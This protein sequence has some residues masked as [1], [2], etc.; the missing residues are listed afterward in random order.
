MRTKL[1]SFGAF[2]I[3]AGIHL[4]AI[5]GGAILNSLVIITKPLLL[6]LLGIIYYHQAGRVNKAHRNF[7]LAAL[8]FSWLGDVLLLFQQN[9]PVFFLAGLISFLA[10]H[11]CYIL[12]FGK[13]SVHHAPSIIRQQPWLAL[14]FVAYGLLFFFFISHGLGGMLIPVLV[15]MFVILL[16]GLAALNRFRRV[17]YHSFLLVFA[18]AMSFMLSDSLLAINKFATPFAMAGFLIMVTYIAAQYL[19]V[20][21]SLKQMATES[22]QAT[23]K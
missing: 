21:G 16:M 20:K 6:L 2:Y 17:E 9:D 8:S 10:A 4:A 19:I 1:F 3:I 23:I 18:G 14:L 13:I 12:A 5:L 22:M 11:L 7:M 15:Y